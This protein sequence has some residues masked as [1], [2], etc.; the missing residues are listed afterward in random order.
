MRIITNAQYDAIID[1]VRDAQ[2]EIDSLKKERDMYKKAYEDLQGFC[3]RFCEYKN[4]DFPN[5]D[6]KTYNGYVDKFI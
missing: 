5:S 2:K 3:F 1:I 6:H 4:I